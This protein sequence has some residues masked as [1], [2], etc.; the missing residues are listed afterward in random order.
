MWKKLLLALVVLLVLA[1]IVWQYFK[2][3]PPIPVQAIAPS[4]QT[5]STTLDLNATVINNQIVTI[6]ALLNG[7]IG[8]INVRKGESVEAG[9]GLALL[10]NQEAQSLLDQSR[11][12]LD[13]KRQKFNTATRSYS[14]IRNLSQDGNTSKQTVDDALDTFRSSEAAVTIAE[15]SVTMA[16]LKIKNSTISAPFTG[17]V[18]EQYAETGQWVEAGTPLF[19]LVA[20]EAY[21]IEAHVDASDWA[22]VSVNQSVSLTAES[23]PEKRWQSTVSWIAPSV[24]NNERN[25]KSV[26][27][28]FP[29]GA[30]APP[31]LLGQ[32]VDAELVLK[33]VQNAITL[34]LSAMVERSP[35]K[36]VV[37]ILDSGKAKQITVEVG[38]QNATHAQITSGLAEEDEVIFAWD[39]QLQDGAPVTIE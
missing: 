19:K 26:A 11:A 8:N 1:V 29:L 12:E 32:E 18:I 33:E 27:V 16:E 31:L 4:V 3:A 38:L 36:Y 9:N 15:A 20:A 34:P 13:Y 10:D 14:R 37:F 5:L 2:P 7:K 6:T 25:V 21:L 30:D 17:I 24:A 23:A 35:G 22:L 28:R 39:V